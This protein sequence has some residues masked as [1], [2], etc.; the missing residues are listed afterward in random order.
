MPQYLAPLH[1]IFCSASLSQDKSSEYSPITRDDVGE[2]ETIPR[3]RISPDP[4]DSEFNACGLCSSAHPT[5]CL[6]GL[7]SNS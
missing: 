4:S 2:S 6:C 3:Y 5:D 1:L 7:H